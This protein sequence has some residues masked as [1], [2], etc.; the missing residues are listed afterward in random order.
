MHLCIFPKDFLAHPLEEFFLKEFL[1]ITLIMGCNSQQQPCVRLLKTKSFL[2]LN[3]IPHILSWK[4]ELPC[5]G[6]KG[7]ILTLW[8]VSNKCFGDFKGQLSKYLRH[9]QTTP[10]TGQLCSPSIASGLYNLL[11]KT[12]V[13]MPGY[14]LS[15][16]NN[17]CFLRVKV[18]K[19]I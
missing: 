11:L 19:I 2:F 3:Q 17:R 7:N 4:Q 6:A 18:T 13:A 15:N 1:H 10:E 12:A 16:D 9:L 14:L 8:T 5:W